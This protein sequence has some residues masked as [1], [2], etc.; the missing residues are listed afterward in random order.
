MKS[1]GHGIVDLAEKIRGSNRAFKR[2][3]DIIGEN[4][5]NFENKILAIGH[6]NC[7]AKALKYKAMIEEK[8]KFK[9]IIITTIGATIGTYSGEGGILVS[10]I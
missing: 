10:F 3:V 5:T 9:Q 1:D 7:Y 2:F 4:G 6:A 8:Y